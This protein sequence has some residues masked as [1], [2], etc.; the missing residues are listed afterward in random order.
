MED[1]VIFEEA[2]M[3]GANKWKKTH[4]AYAID[5]LSKILSLELSQPEYLNEK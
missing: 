5:R 1:I 4:S 3:T 2:K